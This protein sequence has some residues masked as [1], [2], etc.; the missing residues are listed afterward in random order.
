MVAGHTLLTDLKN[1][2]EYYSELDQKGRYLQNGIQAIFDTAGISAVVNQFGS[3]LSVF[4]HAGPVTDFASASRSDMT[5]FTKFF[6]GL[7]KRGVHLP[8]SG[9]ESWFLSNALQQADL[10]KTLDVIAQTVTEL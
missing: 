9:Y 6:H 2:P 4:F 1:H 7:L 8:P 3:M 10:D 5:R